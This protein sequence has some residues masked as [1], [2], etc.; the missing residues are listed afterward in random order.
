MSSLGEKYAKFDELDEY[1]PEEGEDDWKLS[2]AEIKAK[3]E[4]KRDELIQ[5][6]LDAYKEIDEKLKRAE[7]LPPLKGEEEKKKDVGSW[8]E[9]RERQKKGLT[10]AQ[11]D[12]FRVVEHVLTQLA[13][14]DEFQNDL[15]R[16]ALQKAI[17]HWTNEARLS[18]DECDDLFDEDS[19]EFQQFLKP[20]LAKISRL[21]AASKAA[22]IG[23]PIDAVRAR[24]TTI[25]EVKNPKKEPEKQLTEAE[26]REKVRKEFEDRIMADIP[27]PQPF[28]WKRLIRQLLFQM[29]FMGCTLIYFHFVMKP[30]LADQV[31]ELEKQAAADHSS[32]VDPLSFPDDHGEVDL[33]EL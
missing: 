16:P 29:A 30:K 14:D 17:K 28:S 25:F 6:E 27:P 3:K 13:A 21:E 31:A 32:P 23:V 4:K 22:G 11:K 18:K 24:R 15:K 5:K 19:F 12:K 10:E 7:K 20:A 33:G 9:G 1:E 2:D 26:Q 8:S